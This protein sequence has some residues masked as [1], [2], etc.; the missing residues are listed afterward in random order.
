MILEEG[1]RLTWANGECFEFN[2]RND[3]SRRT[4]LDGVTSFFYDSRDNLTRIESVRGIWQASYDPLARRIRKSYARRR[5]DYYWDMDRLAAEIDQSGRVR[6]YVYADSFAFVP[7]LFMG[8]DSVDADPG[9]GRRYFLGCSQIGAPVRIDDD[10]GNTVWCAV[11]IPRRPLTL[12][13][14]RRSTAPCVSLAIISMKRPGF[15]TTGSVTTALSWDATCSRTPWGSA[16]VSISMPI[17]R[18]R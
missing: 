11:S 6:L 13:R 17:P 8:Y 1:N 12:T 3:V 18:A 15:T 4:G 7:L 9:S 14:H 5:I 10:L 2:N 16:A